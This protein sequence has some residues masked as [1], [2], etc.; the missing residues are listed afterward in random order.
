MARA[1]A[2]G[3]SAKGAHAM[4]SAN[5]MRMFTAGIPETSYDAAQSSPTIQPTA[6]HSTRLCSNVVLW[7]AHLRLALQE[8]DMSQP[9]STHAVV[10][11]SRGR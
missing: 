2:N 11:C 9:V 4:N 3:C 1:C 6:A 8:L 5:T 10:R 7:R